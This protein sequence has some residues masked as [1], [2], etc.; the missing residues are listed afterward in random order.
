M[1]LREYYHLKKDTF[2]VNPDTDAAV[3]FGGAELESRI[4]ERILRDLNQDRAVPKFMI[5][6]PYGGG[7]THNLRHIEY[8]LGTDAALR[9]GL[10]HLRPLRYELAPIRSKERWTT[11]HTRIMNAIGF[12]V[13]REAA[14]TVL[15]TPE[16]ATDPLPHLVEERV[17]RYGETAIQAS[18][19][20]IFR[21]LLFGGRQATLSWEWLKG[22][23]LTVDETQMLATQANLEEPADLIHALLN[24]AS[25]VRAGTDEKLLILMDEGEALG[26]ITNADSIMEFEFSFRRLFDDDNDVLGLIIAFEHTPGLGRV[27]AVLDYE[28]IRRRVGYDDGYIDL[29]GHLAAAENAKRFIFDLLQHLVDQQAAAQTIDEQGLATEPEFFPFD[30]DAIDLVAEFAS[31]DPQNSLPSQIIQKMQAAVL[32]AWL[33]RDQSSDDR[34]LVDEA[35]ITPVLYPPS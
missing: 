6:G 4:R 9:D 8:V 7:K 2:T 14:A 32:N 34:R 33:G 23:K 22:R 25:L 35:V 17:L 26:N 28:A 16:R 19:A 29:T 24:V 12:E 27:P 10:P 30:E 5:F 21:N 18:Q 3:Y 20:Q 11:V 31:S 15:G 1:N 13:V